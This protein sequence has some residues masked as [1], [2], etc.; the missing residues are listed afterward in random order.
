[1]TL[2][3][4]TREEAALANVIVEMFQA[5]VSVEREM[6]GRGKE[7]RA[8]GRGGWRKERINNGEIYSSVFPTAEVVKILSVWYLNGKFM[9]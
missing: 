9:L 6:E 2:G 8:R 1:M 7:Q 3:N 5:S 4:A